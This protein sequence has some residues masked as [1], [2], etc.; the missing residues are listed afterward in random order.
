ML[1]LS[2]ADEAMAFVYHRGIPIGALR[3]ADGSHRTSVL[4][5]GSRGDF[6]I[7]R[8]SVVAKCYGRSELLRLTACFF[9]EVTVS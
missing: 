5:S 4:F 3:I 9:P 7:L 2:F 1:K 6:E 8:P